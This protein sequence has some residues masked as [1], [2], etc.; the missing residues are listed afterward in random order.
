[1]MIAY[2]GSAM[3]FTLSNPPGSNNENGMYAEAFTPV[4]A[5]P[6]PFWRFQGYIVFEFSQADTDDSL[7]TIIHDYHRAPALCY[8]DIA[9][10]IAMPHINLILG[11]DSC[12]ADQW[13]LPNNGPLMTMSA[14]TSFITGEPWHPDSTYCFL[15]LAF[16]TTPH[17]I[18][19]H[20][21]TEQNI[22]FGQNG[23]FGALQ[24]Q[25][26]SPATVGMAEQVNTSPRIWPNPAADRVQLQLPTSGS[27][28][29][30]ISD[31]SGR[32][33]LQRPID[34]QHTL[35]VAD[36][37]DGIYQLALRGNDGNMFVDRVVVKH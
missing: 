8:T 5:T 17:Y 31:A 30:T 9:D 12:Y 3:H 13:I 15:A 4:D 18:D 34:P 35:S 6:D 14:T 21:G 25:C 28:Q 19:P 36:L 1:M 10:T 23:P 27:W 37:A 11:A 2:D 22:L 24:V 29:A 32:T 33:V 20:C 26:I 16:A 7:L